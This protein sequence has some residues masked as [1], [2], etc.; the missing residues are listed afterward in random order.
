MVLCLQRAIAIFPYYV[1]VTRSESGCPIYLKNLV[2]LTGFLTVTF[3]NLTDRP[4][5]SLLL[6]FVW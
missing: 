5:P 1:R 4:Q 2:S 3:L 6:V